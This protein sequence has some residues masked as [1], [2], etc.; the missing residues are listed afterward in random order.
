MSNQDGD[1]TVEWHRCHS[2]DDWTV[3]LEELEPNPEPNREPKVLDVEF[4]VAIDPKRPAVD[5]GVSIEPKRPG[6]E[7]EKLLEEFVGVVGFNG[8]SKSNGSWNL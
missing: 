2:R 4:G 7:F 3:L 8:S 1:W 5:F 6:V